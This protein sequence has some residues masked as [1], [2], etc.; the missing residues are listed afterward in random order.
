MMTTMAALLLMAVCPSPSP[1]AGAQGKAGIGVPVASAAMDLNREGKALYRDGHFSEARAKYGQALLADPDFLAPWLNRACAFARE[2]NF[3]QASKEATALIRQAYVPW[4]REVME[5]ADLGAL[6]IRPQWMSALQSTLAEA[7]PAWGKT[8]Q[9]GVLLMARNQPPV[10]LQGQGV[11]VLGLNQDLYAWIPSSG[12][13]LQVTSEDGRV[14]AFVRSPDGHKLVLLRAG[15]L[16]RTPGQPDLLRGLGVRELDLDHMTSGP[17]VELPGDAR[18]V[19][20]WPAAGAA[21]LRVTGPLGGSGLFRFDGKTLEPAGSGFSRPLPGARVVR[22]TNR[23]VLAPASEQSDGEC[24]F[25]IRDELDPKGLSR[26]RVQPRKGKAFF[27]DARY[28]AGLAG[29]PFPTPDETTSKALSPAG[30]TR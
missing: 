12:R 4:G 8:V 25:S 13:F 6:Q 22:L 26:V 23:G 2:E 3:E 19:S 24:A 15:R 7:A 21:I 20:F 5:A 11:L 14:L 29:L 1:G 28:G 30:K 10:K 9:G 16:L 27:L 18:E 17:V